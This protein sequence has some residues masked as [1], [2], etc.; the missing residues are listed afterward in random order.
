MAAKN[1]VHIIVET[2]PELK[3]RVDALL[4]HGMRK[5]LLNSLITEMVEF[6]E[7]GMHNGADAQS[8]LGQFMSRKVG[9]GYNKIE[10]T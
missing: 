4:P 6:I 10:G 3:Q 9:I 8:I 7:V 1:R 5:I 2:S